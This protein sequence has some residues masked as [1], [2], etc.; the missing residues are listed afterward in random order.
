MRNNWRPN[1]NVTNSHPTIKMRAIDFVWETRRDAV[2]KELKML[3][4]VDELDPKDRR[5]FQ[6][7]NA[8]A[9][10][11]LEKMSAEERAEIELGLEIR[12]TKGNPENVQRWYVILPIPSYILNP[13]FNRGSQAA[14]RNMAGRFCKHFPKSAG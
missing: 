3:L 5:H 13:S 10:L 7:R 2:E 4:E 6:Q 14:P 1:V 12:R 9:K 11:A 8:A